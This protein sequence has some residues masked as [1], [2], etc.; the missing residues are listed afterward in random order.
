MDTGYPAL[1]SDPKVGP[2]EPQ[3][4]QPNKGDSPEDPPGS[5]PLSGNPN[6]SPLHTS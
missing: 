5:K 4:I 2:P 6:T 3:P 1:I